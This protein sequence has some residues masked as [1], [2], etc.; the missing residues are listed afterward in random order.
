MTVSGLL[1]VLHVIANVVWIGSILAVAVT[2]MSDAGDAKL[3]GQLATRIYS[4]LAV[5]AFIVSF[6]S[7]VAVLAMSV[8]LYFVATKWMHAKLT[9]GLVV[10]ALHHIIG[11]RAKRMASGEKAA[12]GPAGVLAAVLL[13][14]AAAAVALAVL[15]P[16]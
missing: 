10:I 2:L 8:Q 1:I 12:P 11:A 15:K 16:F 14:S 7:A 5:P 6:G 4:R 13:V 9:V 3:R